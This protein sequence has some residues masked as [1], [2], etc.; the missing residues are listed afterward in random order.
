[1]CVCVKIL[2]TNG[3]KLDETLRATMR[4]R[5][6]KADDKIF[7]VRLLPELPPLPPAPPPPP[8]AAAPPPAPPPPVGPLT[9]TRGVVS[10]LISMSS[11]S[12]DFDQK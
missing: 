10:P 1:M 8:P 2:Y 3:R 7:D 11:D 4:Q 6:S 5:A 9:V 12:L